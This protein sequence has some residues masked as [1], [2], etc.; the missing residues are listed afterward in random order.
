MMRIRAAAL[1]LVCMA[2]WPGGGPHAAAWTQPEGS[3]LFIGTAT[4]TAGNRFFEDGRLTRV[5]DYRKLETT[6][7]IEYG[8]TNWLTVVAT[9][10]LRWTRV[11]TTPSDTFAGL[12]TSDLGA[13]VRLWQDG[14]S[15][16]STQALV[17]IPGATDDRRPAQFGNTDPELDLRIL[18]GHSF[19]AFER[20]AFVNL[21]AAYRLRFDDPPN[22][23]RADI[24]LG[25]RPAER[26]LLLGQSFTV[27]SDGSG[28]GPWRRYWYTKAQTSAVYE[29]APGW[30]LQAGLVTTYAGD[31]ALQENGGLVAL[32]RRF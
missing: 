10:A 30:S 16:L 25:I 5:P 28:S 13:R 14:S 3:G 8:A 20:P 4:Y 18:F 22:E 19:Q 29:F 24:T 12:G 1:L 11:D 21:E 23:F 15:V 26:W 31:N 6:F 17:R 2:C 9:P 7:L 32:W 27:V